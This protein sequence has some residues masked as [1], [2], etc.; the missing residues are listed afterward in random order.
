LL[1]QCPYPGCFNNPSAGVVLDHGVTRRA[2]YDFYV[3]PMSVSQGTATPTHFT[4]L[5]DSG[6]MLVD[7]VQ[8][9]A[10]AMTFMYFNW[11]GNVKVS[12]D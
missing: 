12:S 2:W 6:L 1:L 3:I 10:Y 11:P 5:Y 4:V 7:D 9:I 8:R